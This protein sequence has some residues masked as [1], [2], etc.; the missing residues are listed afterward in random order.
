L[1]TQSN[2]PHEVHSGDL[3][4]L[5]LLALIIQRFMLLSSFTILTVI[6]AVY[7]IMSISSYTLSISLLVLYLVFYFFIRSLYLF[8]LPRTLFLYQIFRF[9]SQLR[10]DRTGEP[11]ALRNA[12]IC[13]STKSRNRP[14]KF[15]LDHFP[16]IRGVAIESISRA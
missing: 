2:S 9:L 7:P 4:P 8:P 14:C 12:S 6:L 5:R 11:K 10:K 3:K 1:D 13:N 16:A 15:C